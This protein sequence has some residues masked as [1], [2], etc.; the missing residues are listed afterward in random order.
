MSLY[1]TNNPCEGMSQAQIGYWIEQ[2][3]TY[4][5]DEFDYMQSPKETLKRKTG[6]CED[7]AVLYLWLVY[8][9]HGIKLSVITV[10]WP[11]SK[12]DHKMVLQGDKIIEPQYSYRATGYPVAYD[13]VIMDYSED[14]SMSDIMYVTPF[15]SIYVLSTLAGLKGVIE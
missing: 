11:E 2:N 1:N 5:A 15:D 14:Y 6:D 3:I 12:T 7:F 10:P 13:N 9:N 4:K 8:K